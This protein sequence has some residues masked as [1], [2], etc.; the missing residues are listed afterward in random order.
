MRYVLFCVFFTIG[1]GAIALSILVD[2]EI[3]NYYQN[4]IHLARIEEGN[5]RIRRLTEQYDAQIRQLRQDPQ[6]LAKLQTITFGSEPVANGAVLPKA[7]EESLNAAREA[8]LKELKRQEQQPLTP[9]WVL[10]CKEPKNR[11]IIFVAGAALVL[12]TFIFFGTTPRRRPQTLP[13]TPDYTWQTP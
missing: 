1:A 2:P 3:S 10:R 8:L 7:S 6:L 9:A 11:K 12:T 5:A 4:R 13:P